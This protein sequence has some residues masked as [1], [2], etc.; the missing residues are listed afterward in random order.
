MMSAKIRLY[1][2]YLIKTIWS[3]FNRGEL[4]PSDILKLKE[5]KETT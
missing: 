3:I 4:F 2:D 1:Y 5:T